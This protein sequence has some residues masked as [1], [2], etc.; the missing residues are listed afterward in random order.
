M[1]QRYIP[2]TVNS[3]SRAVQGA[4]QGAAKAGIEVKT[5]RIKPNGDVVINGDKE[6]GDVDAAERVTE[7]E[8]CET[9]EQYNAWR[10]KQGCV[11]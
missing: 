3:V 7:P 6:A 8:D 10:E 1:G 11:S 5:L 2:F 9:L 4:I